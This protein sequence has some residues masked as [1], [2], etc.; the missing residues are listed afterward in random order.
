MDNADC[1]AV[2]WE[3]HLRPSRDDPDVFGTQRGHYTEGNEL[4]R[5][6]YVSLEKRLGFKY[7]KKAGATNALVR[8]PAVLTKATFILSLDCD[9]YINNC[10]A[11]REDM[12][13]LMDPIVGGRGCATFSFLSG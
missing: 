9:H 10:K 6:V 8:V 12:C 11:L 3:Q 1:T 5:L 4:P 13:P 7:H 2:A